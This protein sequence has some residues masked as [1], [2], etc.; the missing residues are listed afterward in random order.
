[1]TSPEKKTSTPAPVENSKLWSEQEDKKTKISENNRKYAEWWISTI[2]KKAQGV[3]Y[4][5][6]FLT[7]NTGK[8]IWAKNAVR[9]KMYNT[10]NG[11]MEEH[12]LYDILVLL[13][14]ENKESP[15]KEL[16]PDEKCQVNCVGTYYISYDLYKHISKLWNDSVKKEE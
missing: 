14:S 12:S 8:K 3:I 15:F 6:K 7:E 1:M 16:L 13:S 11:F 10:L 5:V 2:S 4:V 9:V